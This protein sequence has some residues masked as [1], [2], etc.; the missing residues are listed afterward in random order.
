MADNTSAGFGS[1]IYQLGENF[2]REEQSLYDE[3]SCCEQRY[4]I[5]REIGSGSFKKI[6]E[7]KDALTNRHL[8]LATLKEP[9]N[10]VFEEAF[11]REARLTAYLQ[12]PNII[13]VYDIGVNE[14]AQAY[15]TMHLIRGEDLSHVLEK[16]EKLDLLL[17]IYLR[18]C[19]AVAYAH[20]KGVLHLDLKPANIRVSSYGEVLVCDW[21]L[22]RNLD[23]E[24]IELPEALEKSELNKAF[25]LSG[26]IKGTPGYM[27]PEQV[28]GTFVNRQTDIYAL[29]AI[30]YE[31]LSGVCT[32]EG[33]KLAE[34]LDII[35]TGAIKA[36]SLVNKT[37]RPLPAAVEAVCMKALSLNAAERYSTVDELIDDI[38]MWR[39]GFTT[40]AEDASFF[41]ATLLFYRRNWRWC[42]A[43]AIALILLFALSQRFAGQLREKDRT[44]LQNLRQYR[45]EKELN[46]KVAADLVRIYGSKAA[47]AYKAYNFE[48][49]KDLALTALNLDPG[50]SMANMYYG[51]SFFIHGHYH[52]GLDYYEKA[53]KQ[54]DILEDLLELGKEFRRTKLQSAFKKLHWWIG[55]SSKRRQ[56]LRNS[57]LIAQQDLF[58]DKELTELLTLNARRAHY[59]EK[60]E[61]AGGVLKL[62]GRRYKE[63]DF[64]RKIHRI[65]TLFIVKEYYSQKDIKLLMKT[66]KVKYLTPN[67]P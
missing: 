60:L 17:E 58:N 27:A 53:S 67:L 57:C 28:N 48:N 23:G 4:E 64:L 21:G 20:S 32:V 50:D 49:S 13:S 9:D 10:A 3:I 26:H 5:I 45:K 42:S 41:R 25:T 34:V 47:A 8:A 29:G 63:I 14:Q 39:R 40:K 7:V 38:N 12:H 52:Q 54:E 62:S 59:A 11:L 44:E 22:A 1:R 51:N 6:L 61:F 19:E 66:F 56:H 18:I 31:M 65:K 15:F 37:A 33:D 2:Q 30:L 36:P 43:I 46:Q 35:K 24:D 55:K 16:T